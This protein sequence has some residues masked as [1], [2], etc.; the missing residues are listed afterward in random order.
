M[1]KLGFDCHI[2]L[3]GHGYFVQPGSYRMTRLRNATVYRTHGVAATIAAPAT[4][5]IDPALPAEAPKKTGT[6]VRTVDRGPNMR[7]W[8]MTLLCSNTLCRY[9]GTPMGPIG[10]QLR[11]QLQTSYDKVATILNFTDPTGTTYRVTFSLY[12]ET[13]EDLR[14]QRLGASFLAGITLTES[15]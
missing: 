4:P 10:L 9:D 12:T 1:S 13:I 5:P 7:T 8:T 15:T 14:T 6:P 2:I 11:D 3:D